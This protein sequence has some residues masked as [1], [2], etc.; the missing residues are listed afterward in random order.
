MIEGG[1]GSE[2][3]AAG[4]ILGIAPHVKPETDVR[5]QLHGEAGFG[6]VEDRSQSGAGPFRPVAADDIGDGEQRFGTLL[7]MG[8]GR[9]GGGINHA[10]MAG[11]PGESGR[12]ALLPV[13]EPGQ[14]ALCL[15]AGLG[16]YKAIHKSGGRFA[17]EHNRDTAGREGMG[18]W[19]VGGEGF[20]TEKAIP[21]T[22]ANIA[23]SG[24]D[25]GVEHG[26]QGLALGESQGVL[27]VVE[28][29]SREQGRIESFSGRGT[30]SA[31]EQLLHDRPRVG[32]GG[33]PRGTAKEIEQI[34]AEGLTRLWL[35]GADVE[36]SRG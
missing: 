7:G 29:Q 14:Q 27:T 33:E 24:T 13:G 15:G 5:E 4:E 35:R 25:T 20:R 6:A 28:Q 16:G 21:A 11:L 3:I 10:E 34:E 22:S 8:C 36:I 12:I 18:Q 31:P 30:R 26:D 2:E 1:K 9:G 32:A 23:R 17:H 19:R